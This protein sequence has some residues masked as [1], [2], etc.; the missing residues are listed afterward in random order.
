[1][2]RFEITYR[3]TVTKIVEADNWEDAEDNKY[4]D[5]PYPP[6]TPD[7]RVGVTASECFSARVEREIEERPAHG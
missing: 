7:A 4:E 6:V 2:A 1:M 5:V 3:L